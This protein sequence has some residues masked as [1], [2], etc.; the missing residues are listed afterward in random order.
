MLQN[1][2][3]TVTKYG[4]QEMKKRGWK[5]NILLLAVAATLLGTTGR[6]DAAE[7]SGSEETVGAGEAT[8]ED[9]AAETENAA[10]E[11]EASAAETAALANTWT[12]QDNNWYFYNEEGL[13]QTG[14]M[15]FNNRW[16]FFDEL[17]IMQTGW[18]QDEGKWYFLRSNGM[19]KTGWQQDAGKWYFFTSSGAMK[20]GWKKL[21]GKWYFFRG[22]GAML[23]G[24]K[25]Y[26]GNWYYMNED[27]EMVIGSITI[28]GVEYVF[29]ASGCYVD[30]NEQG[31][32]DAGNGQETTGGSA[33]AYTDFTEQDLLYMQRCV[34]TETRD[35]DF[36]SKTHV[37]SV[38]MNRVS[39]GNFGK[40]PYD[41]VTAKYQFAYRREDISESTI[42]AVNYVIANGDTA[43]GALFF[44]SMTWRETFCGR[45]YMF[46]DNCGH[47]FY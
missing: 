23:T 31:T 34:E 16:Y 40:T 41:V 37:A 2:E 10:E 19:M 29:D 24:W 43:Q 12:K 47:H 15:S 45:P 3:V 17:G 21:S 8:G 42:E 14:W 25:K 22:T 36:E 46:T 9:A 5:H 7:V 1:E 28:N 6:A 26:G 4:V 30:P 20:T 39:A 32:E 27:G 35:C 44:H 38:I 13:L 33:W 18:L 11:A